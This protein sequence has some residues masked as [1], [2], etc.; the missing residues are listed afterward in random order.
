MHPGDLSSKSEIEP[1]EKGEIFTPTI[2]IIKM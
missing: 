1:S 2:F